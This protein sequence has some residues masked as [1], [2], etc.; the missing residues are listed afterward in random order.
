MCL[1]SVVLFFEFDM[2]SFVSGVIEAG[3]FIS[4]VLKRETMSRVAGSILRRRSVSVPVRYREV[5]A[6]AGSRSLS[7]SFRSGLLTF[8]TYYTS[9]RF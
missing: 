1:F 2:F 7:T 6:V 4:N 8:K 5:L 3:S 9:I